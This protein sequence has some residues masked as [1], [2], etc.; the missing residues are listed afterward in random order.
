MKNK[1][2]TK[3]ELLKQIFAS[4]RSLKSGNQEQQLKCAMR[5]SQLTAILELKQKTPISEEL[6]TANGFVKRD[7]HRAFM[8]N[9]H[10]KRIVWCRKEHFGRWNVSISHLSITN[11]FHSVIIY[12]STVAELEDA[13]TIAGIIR[14]I[15][16]K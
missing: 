4:E 16:I 15:D 11:E 7:K 9:E 10:D 13:M 12:I 6:L 3:A 2:S 1:L 8:F 14:C 5:V